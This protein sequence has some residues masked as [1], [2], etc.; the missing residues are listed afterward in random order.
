MSVCYWVCSSTSSSTSSSNSCS[1]TYIRLLSQFLPNWQAHWFKLSLHSGA[2]KGVTLRFTQQKE[3]QSWEIT[4]QCTASKGTSKQ[5]WST[6]ETEPPT[7]LHTFHCIFLTIH[8]TYMLTLSFYVVLVVTVRLFPVVLLEPSS[9]DK[10]YL[11]I[12]LCI[13]S[14]LKQQY[15]FIRPTKAVCS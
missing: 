6:W 11:T 1:A 5:T 10:I 9:P 13:F 2:E 14:I 12:N 8:T 4:L 15:F 7:R 3:G